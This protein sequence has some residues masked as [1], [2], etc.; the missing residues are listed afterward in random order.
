MSTGDSSGAERET[1]SRKLSTLT[2]YAEWLDRYGLDPLLGLIPGAGDVVG[3]L[4][5]GWILV[6]A[7]RL[8]VSRATLLRLIGNVALDAVLGAIPIIGDIFDFAWKANLRNIT[9]LSRHLASP[10]GA[11]RAD[12]FFVA[13]VLG[14][15]IVL[16]VGALTL[17][18]W[19]TRLLLRAVG[20]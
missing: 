7:L 1:S 8:G 13:C 18:V 17:G 10:S 3:A 11:R 4:L 14:G 9:L 19:L 6:E 16:L 5:A 15:V 2:R 12:R 20:V